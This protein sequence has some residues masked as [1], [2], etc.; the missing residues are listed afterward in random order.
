M[1]YIVIDLET[2]GLDA[3]YSKI[4]EIGA[5]KIKNNQIIDK[6]RTFVHIE[7]DLTFE[8]KD[9]TGITDDD[10][11]FAP[12]LDDAI[13]M[14]IDFSEDISFFIAHN[15]DFEKSFLQKH[16]PFHIKWLDTIEIAKIVKPL[17]KYFRLSALLPLYNLEND[18]A[19]RALSDAE[20]TAKL[21]LKMQE[22]LNNLDC[23]LWE[24][25]LQLANNA[26]SALSEFIKITGQNVLSKFPA[27]TIRG[28][29]TDDSFLN[30]QGNLL[31]NNPK[32]NNKE[33]NW[34]WYLNENRIT[35]FFDRLTA[36]NDGENTF[37]ARPQ[38]IEM[39]KMVADAFNEHYAL[40]IEAGTGTGK[41]M[42]YLLPA[43]IY[44]KGS[45]M[46]VFISTNT[47]NLQEQ[48]IKKDIP[49]LKQYSDE[50]FSAVIVKGRSNY[51]CTRKWHNAAKICN[52]DNL[53]LFLR[54]AHW[55]VIT[56]S[57]DFSELN[58]YG[59]EWEYAYGL[60]SAAET[61]ASYTCPYYK[62][63]CYVNNIRNQAKKA[64]II[65]INHSLLLATSVIGEGNN[66]ILPPINNII[67]DEAHQLESVAEKQFSGY[68]SQKNL[69]KALNA[70]WQ[71]DKLTLIINTLKKINET[72]NTVKLLE[73]VNQ[74][75]V[76][77]KTSS[78]EF[79]TI[80]EDLFNN[81]KQPFDKQLRVCNQR[82]NESLWQP[83]ENSLS[84]LILN[85]NSLI[86]NIKQIISE[87]DSLDDPFFSVDLL[88]SFKITMS[89]LIEFRDIAQ[90]IIDNQ[91][92]N[93]EECVIWLDKRNSFEKTGWS[94][95]PVDIKNALNQ[96]LYTDKL[97]VVMTSATLNSTGF[98]FFIDEIGLNLSDLTIKTHQLSS[99]F[100][101]SKNCKILLAADISD[102]TKTS[103]IQI[104]EEL[105]DYLYHLIK[106]ANGRSLVLFTSY[107]QQRAVY[108][109]LKPRLKEDGIKVLAHGISGGRNNIVE[110]QKSNP[111][112][113]I[114][115]VNSFWEGVDIQGEALSLLIIVR[116]PFNPPNTPTTE[117]K[118]ERLEKD[119]KNPFADYSLPQAI[120]RFKQ[121]FG[122]L[123]RSKEDKGV[124]C[125]LDSRI[126]SKSYGNKFL[127]ALPQ[128]YTKRLTKQEMVKE[129]KEFLN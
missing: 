100:D 120:I 44:A 78:K 65:I 19:H 109:M 128:T 23:D 129:I 116:L 66:S 85:I 71:K 38:Q 121:G 88:G 8:I 12:E 29:D 25:F 9:L 81:C 20:A 106:S 119:G 33:I 79:F 57:G 98:D 111:K 24:K 105:S 53:P 7:E 55:S 52:A 127:S 34:N 75:I 99:P 46:P 86:N 80:S 17:E 4:I 35:D 94:I 45:G 49:L 104:Q 97:S 10:L 96:Y 67:I 16:M 91:T 102:Y 1:D 77:T 40:L 5:V 2:T 47:I 118:F 61:C 32:A 64:D 26:D 11:A 76:E 108:N 89:N 70:L 107:A 18:E 93:G 51:I 122:R 39:S 125:V 87:F 43:A 74:L 73:T 115:G 114:L 103:E 117:A 62:H 95:C 21:F 113:C 84:N 83:V 41:S 36:V 69:D 110:S 13:N 48:L 22:D 54:I 50:D 68:I 3:D 112:S 63:K 59:K 42:A 14:L 124:V 90:A 31:M 72:E 37:E 60:T 58:L 6:F 82:Y 28:F 56:T 101:Y 123:I 30:Y 15:A 27:K 126:W 92:V